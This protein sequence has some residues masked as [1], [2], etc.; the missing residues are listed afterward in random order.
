MMKHKKSK[1]FLRF[2]EKRNGKRIK[3]LREKRKLYKELNIQIQQLERSVSTLTKRVSDL[4]EEERLKIDRLMNSNREHPLMLLDSPSE[5]AY[6]GNQY[7]IKLRALI[8]ES[9]YFEPKILRL[10]IPDSKAKQEAFVEYALTDDVLETDLYLKYVIEDML[11][12]LRYC[13]AS[14]MDRKYGW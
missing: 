13:R 5:K 10:S 14:N 12:Q 1:G 9:P 7:P 2:E 3:E 6:K 8:Y 4:R 11:I